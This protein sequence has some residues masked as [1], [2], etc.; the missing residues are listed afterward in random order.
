MPLHRL[1]LDLTDATGRAHAAWWLADRYGRDHDE[2]PVAGPL[3]RGSGEWVM[4][5]PTSAR[6][7]DWL[8]FG[9]KSVPSL[10]DLDPADHRLLPDGSRWE[11]AEALRRVVLHVAGV[12]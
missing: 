4:Y 10:A 2:I 6:A 9:P 5:A 11:E 3:H 12:P 8:R 7:D 1:L